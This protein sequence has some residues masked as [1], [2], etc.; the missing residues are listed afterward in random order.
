MTLLRLGLSGRGLG[1]SLIEILIVAAITVGLTM[2]L[3]LNFRTSA[4]NRAARHQQTAV[5][6]SDIRKAQA[7]TIAGSQFGGSIVCGFGLHYVDSQSYY[8]YAKAPVGDSCV[9]ATFNYAAGD[10]IV[11]TRT[12]N[13]TNMQIQSSF[14]DIF[15]RPPDPKT[16]VNNVATLSTPPTTTSINIILKGSSACTGQTCT[17]ITISTSG[18]IDVSN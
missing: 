7:Q 5:I 9:L 18:S 13:N 12:L 10:L 1:F 15:F 3:V 4:T 14:L 8:L 17:T 16:Y 2:A 11:E 6:V